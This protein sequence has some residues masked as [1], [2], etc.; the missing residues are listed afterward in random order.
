[1]YN[2]AARPTQNYRPAFLVTKLE[3]TYEVTVYE[4]EPYGKEDRNG[5]RKHRLV[6]KV[7]TRPKGW[8]V[9]FPKQRREH[10]HSVHIA[11][12]DEMTRLGFDQTEVPLVDEDGEAVGSVPNRVRKEKGNQEVINA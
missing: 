2:P 7:E 4:M 11:T 12:I 3:G 9:T 10:W 8:L 6:Q 5:D 1:M